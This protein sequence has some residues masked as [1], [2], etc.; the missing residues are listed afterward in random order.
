MKIG[1][2][3]AR[4]GINPRTLRYYER[5]GLLPE[6]GRTSSGYR[7]Y[8]ESDLDRV[9][10]IKTA[11]RLGMALDEIG[12]ILAL[13]HRG[14]R[15][16]GYV[17]DVLHH[18]VAEIDARIAELNRLRNSLMELDEFADRLEPTSSGCKIIDHARRMEAAREESDS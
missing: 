18:Q 4:L 6:P 17:R 9:T 14:E 5:I 16:C 13:R 8:T 7:E 11:Q 2:L 1:E 3:A 12:E 15:P 10:F